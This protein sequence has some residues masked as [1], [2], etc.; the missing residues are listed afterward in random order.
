MRLMVLMRFVYTI[1]KER[2]FTV[3]QSANAA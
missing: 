3:V 1:N 2:G